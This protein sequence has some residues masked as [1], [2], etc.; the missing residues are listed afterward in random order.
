MSVS[1]TGL[2]VR[3]G[4]LFAAHFIGLGLFLPFFPLVLEARGLTVAEIGYVLGISTVVRVVASPVMTNI[5][6]RS[7]RRRLS[8]FVYSMAAGAFLGFFAATTGVASAFIAVAGLMLFWSP[9]VPLSDAY[10]LDVAHNT[11]ADYAR[12]RLWGSVG[13][14]A[15]T[16]FGGWLVEIGNPQMIVAGILIGALSTGVVAISLPRQTQQEKG[17]DTITSDR[18]DVFKTA[19]FT[20]V[21]LLSG[22]SQATHAAVYGF[23]TLY[24][25]GVGVDDF[26]IGILWS[27]GVVAEIVLFFAAGRLGIRFGPVSFLLVGAA[28]SLVRWIAFPFA[29]QFET[30]AALQL[31]HGLSFGA[32]HL[33]IVGFLAKV[34]PQKWSATGQG[35]LSASAGIQTAAGLVVCGPLFALNPAYPFWAMSAVAA[36]ALGGLILMRPMLLACLQETDDVPAG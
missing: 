13:F 18:P 8:I 23:G 19:W 11:G 17:A 3:V 22:L 27:I 34:V 35:L 31:L 7:G 15:A 21:L 10:A 25:R 24:W 29:E 36:A 32:A 26:S 16:L 4:G 2:S 12:M 5:S 9:I 33:G 1:R 14:V 28:A 6:D 20:A 30:M